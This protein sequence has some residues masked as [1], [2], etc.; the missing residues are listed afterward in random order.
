[1]CK[2]SPQT[3]KC[4]VDGEVAK[5]WA[6]YA[7][8]NAMRLSLGKV[9]AACNFNK[10]AFENRVQKSWLFS[11]KKE[12]FTESGWFSEE[13]MT[14]ELGYSKYAGLIFNAMFLLRSVFWKVR[15]RTGR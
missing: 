11:D 15:S 6:S 1:M 2:V 13:Q 3:G 5:L 10:K 14:S 8:E 9:L 7:S 12:H 4:S